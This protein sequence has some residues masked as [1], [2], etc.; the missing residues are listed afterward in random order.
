MPNFKSQKN[1][2]SLRQMKLEIDEEEKACWGHITEGFNQLIEEDAGDEE[3]VLSCNLT[4]QV[5]KQTLS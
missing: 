2:T 5:H 1:F 3:I 4:N